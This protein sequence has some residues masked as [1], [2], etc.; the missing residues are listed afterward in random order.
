MARPQFDD[1]ER[2]REDNMTRTSHCL[3]ATLLSA[4]AALA[5]TTGASPQAF[6]PVTDQVLANP[7]PG[8]WLMMNRTFDE[9]RFS[10][11]TQINKANVGQLRM[12]WSRG[13]P[14][15]TQEST[16]IVHNG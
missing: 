3:A 9:Q 14:I 13:L 8:D 15:G 7:D 12:A 16:P 6:A 1:A 4:C 10:P 5:F 11:L 2:R